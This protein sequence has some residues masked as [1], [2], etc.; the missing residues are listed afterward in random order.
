MRLL[1][2]AALAALLAVPL[3]AAAA[4]NTHSVPLF[5][6]DQG[7]SAQQ[8]F[9]RIANLSSRN[10]TVFILAYDDDGWEY[11]L[12]SLPLAAGQTKG[13]NS[14]DLENGGTKG[15]SHGIGRGIGDWRLELYTD[16]N[17]QV[18]AYVRN[19]SP[20]GWFVTAMHD[21]APVSIRGPGRYQVPFLNP[22][23][24]TAIAS[25]LRI[26]NPHNDEVAVT[27]EGRDDQ[28][29]D[30]L[31]S[32]RLTV[33]PQAARTLTAQA[34][35]GGGAS[36]GG[37]PFDGALGDG[38][39]K[40]RLSVTSTRPLHVMSL[41]DTSSGHLANLSTAPPSGAVAAR[42]AFDADGDGLIE[43][44]F[45]EQLDAIRHDLDGNGRADNSNDHDAYAAAFPDAAPGEYRGYELARPL[46][47]TD[48]GSYASGE[49]N[50]DWVRGDRR[51]ASAK[52]WDPIGSHFL[53]V[54]DG[55]GHALSNLFIHRVEEDH[56][57]LFE[58]VGTHFSDG[59]R[60]GEIRNLGLVGVDV[61]GRLW[62]G[63]LAGRAIVGLVRA[64]YVAGGNVAGFDSAAVTTAFNDRIA[65][66]GGLAGSVSSNA[67]VVASYADVD[68]AGSGY[69][70]GLVGSN[71]GAVVAGYA[72]GLVEG[73]GRGFGGLVG[74][75]TA[76][77]SIRASY[78]VGKVLGPEQVGGLV[79]ER[80]SRSGDIRNSY[81]NTDT[82]GDTG[83]GSGDTSGA[84]GR[85]T[86]ELTAPTGYE[87]IYADWN[88][89][90]DEDGEPDDPWDFGNNRQYP[91]L[92]VDF[93]GDEIPS[94]QE[95]GEQPR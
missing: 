21:A 60:L 42:K 33:P 67:R 34:L 66:V 28:G 74:D 11:G 92:K 54:F 1:P 41:L 80:R 76:G 19:P 51:F 18:R 75:L 22:A 90:L 35:E 68:V 86:D 72:F 9:V 3:Q 16:L 78:A 85:N 73:K 91:A 25:R 87:G 8:G 95:F 61:T 44:F 55:N 48:P 10:G 13:L 31:D 58:L 70:G 7:G 65:I 93:D 77:G 17:I 26:A 46:D 14:S 53:A 84:Q 45:L 88:L 37:Y 49:V 29:R 36:L 30:G 81:W 47:F 63:A 89:D 40:W 15:L 24:N 79:G 27:I 94:W 20:G 38:D 39:G 12:V 57:G 82:A 56:V 23:S 52:G 59:P 64:C 71:G 62:V 6:R 5:M 83:V 69:V 43:V 32:V 2:A 4:Q 50:D